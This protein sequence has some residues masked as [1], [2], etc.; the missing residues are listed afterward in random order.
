MEIVARA[1]RELRRAHLI[2]VVVA[3]TIVQVSS[4][5]LHQTNCASART[6]NFFD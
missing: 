6:R 1:R 2:Q 5:R 4:T 3:V